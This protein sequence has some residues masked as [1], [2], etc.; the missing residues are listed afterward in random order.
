MS[1]WAGDKSGREY[2]TTIVTGLAVAA[3]TA[4]IPLMLVGLVV[5]FLYSQRH[6]RLATG[7]PAHSEPQPQAG[8]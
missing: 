6:S 1:R 7:E 5:Y 2:R 8:P 3:L 4:F